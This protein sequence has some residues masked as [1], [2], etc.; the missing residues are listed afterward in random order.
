MEELAKQQ[1]LI[2]FLPLVAAAIQSVLPRGQRKLS[3]GL[4]LLAMGASC[5]IAVRA[6]LATLGHHEAVR[7][8]YNFTWFNF[9]STKLEMGF[10][11]DPLTAGMAVMVTFVGFWIF[12]NA[13]GYMHED[14]NFTRFFCFLSLFAAAMKKA[15]ITTR[16]GDVGF[17]LGIL[18]L[19]WKTGT[20]NLYDHGNGAL[21]Q[22]GHLATLAGWW[23]LS[24]AT[25]IAV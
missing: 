9:G 6:F 16:I 20:L 13:T 15:F 21:E 8:V 10:I 1:W 4:C 7:E 14:D 24:T 18:M 22:A 5:V 19:Y 3:A 2:P 11:L 23:G 25:T 17:F 12:V